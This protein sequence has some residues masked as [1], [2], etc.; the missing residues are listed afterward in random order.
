MIVQLIA[1][2]SLWLYILGVV[3]AL[4]YVRELVEAQRGAKQSLF[5]LER[6]HAVHR[7]TRAVW[8]I[9]FVVLSV[10]VVAVLSRVVAPRLGGEV[11]SIALDPTSSAPFVATPP[12][13]TPT[14]RPT[15]T[16]APTVTPLTPQPT[17][18]PTPEPTQEETPLP[19]PTLPPVAGCGDPDQN[20]TSPPSGSVVGG[21][22]AVFGTADIKNFQYYKFEV[23]GTQTNGEWVTTA[24]FQTPVRDGQLGTWDTTGWQPGPYDLRLVV[25][26]NTGNFPEP[27]VVSVAV[28]GTGP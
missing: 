5:G 21:V 3:A 14:V 13:D 23:R 2:Y 22:V 10:G 19:Q 6:E 7:R 8:M 25:V 16:T 24:V 28:Q 9:I 1:Q 26:D 17:D 11:P 12:T 18:T 4:Y 20:L 27:C 15:A